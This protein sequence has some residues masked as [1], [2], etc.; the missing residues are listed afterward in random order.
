MKHTFLLKILK[1]IY[2]SILKFIAS[3]I[4]RSIDYLKE[5]NL[6][7]SFEDHN[8]EFGYFG[9]RKEEMEKSFQTFKKHFHKSVFLDSFKIRRFAIIEAT[10]DEKE[11]DYFLEFGVYKA[12]SL[13]FFSKFVK[14]NSIYGFDSFEGLNYSWAGHTEEIGHKDLK[15]KLPKVNNNVTLIPG[16]IEETLEKFIN[17]KKNISIKFIHIDTD[18]YES[19]DYIFKK[20]K[21][22]LQN[23]CI[24]L[25]DELYNYAGWSMGEYKA[26][27]ENFKEEE[28]EFFAFGLVGKQAAIRYK[29]L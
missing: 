5:K 1:S 7:K 13:N 12:A 15:K 4:V 24:I 14:K 25:F 10:K 29:K 16:W 20:V 18:T 8:E 21:P 11:S 9:F 26:L 2:F 6:I 17:E 19:T 27:I 23:N 22:Y 3:F 28:Y